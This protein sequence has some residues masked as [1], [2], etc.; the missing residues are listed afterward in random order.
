MGSVK[1]WPRKQGPLWEQFDWLILVL[2]PLRDSLWLFTF[3]NELLDLN[4]LHRGTH[5]NFPHEF[6]NETTKTLH[7][8]RGQVFTNS[9]NPDKKYLCRQPGVIKYHKFSLSESCSTSRSIA[10]ALLTIYVTIP[11]L[12]VPT[13]HWEKHIVN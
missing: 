3:R 2:S 6:S 10:H 13:G 12:F 9:W 8:F 11:I 7:L 4:F 5:L 1:N